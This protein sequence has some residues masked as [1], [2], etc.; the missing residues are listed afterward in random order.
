MDTSPERFDR[1]AAHADYAATAHRPIALPNSVAVAVVAPAGFAAFAAVVCLIGLTII[2]AIEP[3]LVF[4]V[5]FA[6]L[7][8]AAIGL[9]V[10]GA[11]RGLAYYRAPIERRIA[12]VVRDRTHVFGGD[13]DAR[14]ATTYYVTLQ[15]RDGTRLE[16]TTH[17]ELAGRVVTGDIGVAYVKSRTLVDFVRFDV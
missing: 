15:A 7:G 17:G 5:A 8:A 4:V 16:Y 11:A 2:I 10:A 3:P 9:G 13:E 12:V 6:A 14:A 1:V